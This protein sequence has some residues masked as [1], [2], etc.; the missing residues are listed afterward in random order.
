M[1]RFVCIGAPYSLGEQDPPGS[2]VDLIRASG[3]ADEIGAEWIDVAPDFDNSPDPITAVNRALAAAIADHR[4]FF[5]IIFAGDCLSA[6]GAVRGLMT[7][8]GLGVVWYDAHG[9]FNTPETTPSGYPGGMP[10]AMLVGRGDMLYMQ[11]VGLDPLDERDII[12]TDARDLDPAEGEAVRA[13]AVTLLPDVRDLL[14]AA[15]PT[16]PLY[17]HLDVDVLNLDDMPA[18]GYQAADGPSLADVAA[19]LE[20]VA[21]EG[22]VAG[23]LASLWNQDLAV[24]TR[25]LD[26]TLH[27]VRAFLAGW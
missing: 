25:P 9:D 23:L 8:A 3:F 7:G 5:P 22:H 4:E 20:R 26:N 15:L 24:D 2:E 27:L 12:L 17:I 18:V 14:T 13:S 11:G 19:T 10:L 16:K 21:R 6:L 1:S